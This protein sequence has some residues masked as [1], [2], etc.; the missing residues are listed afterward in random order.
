[1]LLFPP[2]AL[3]RIQLMKEFSKKTVIAA[4][5]VVK[6]LPAT[7]LPLGGSGRSIGGIAPVV[8]DAGRAPAVSWGVN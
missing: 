8:V 5:K 2:T 6:V 7:G 4:K 1:M 3:P